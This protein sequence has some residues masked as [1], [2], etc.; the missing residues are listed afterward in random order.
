[1]NCF[2]QR[3]IRK[4]SFLAMDMSISMDEFMVYTFDP[5]NSRCFAPILG[6]LK[7]NV[8][9][10][11]LDGCESYCGALRDDHGRWQWG[12]TGQCVALDPL[13]ANFQA[14]SITVKIVVG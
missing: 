7:L 4:A 8:H 13:H 5:I 6:Y 12:F 10:R 14:L 9:E 11:F 3:I 2:A 1:M